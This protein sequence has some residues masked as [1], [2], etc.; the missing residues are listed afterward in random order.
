M[1]T[2]TSKLKRHYD[3]ELSRNNCPE[4]DANAKHSRRRLSISSVGEAVNEDNDITRSIQKMKENE[5]RFKGTVLQSESQDSQVQEKVVT[6]KQVQVPVS[7]E[8]AAENFRKH[9]RNRSSVAGVRASHF[10]EDFEKKCVKVTGSVDELNKNGIGYVCRKGLKPESPN[11]D[12]FIIITT[13]NLA[14]YGIF[15]G[16]GPYGHDV[17]NFVQKQLPYKIIEDKEF[18]TNPEKVFTN[19]FLEI[20]E[21]IA[22]TTQK[23]LVAVGNEPEKR[24]TNPQSRCPVASTSANE[25]GGQNQ[26]QEETDSVSDVSFTTESEDEQT[27]DDNADGND[28]TKVKKK[29]KS[30]KPYFDCTMSG[31]TATVLVHLY[32]QKKIYAAYVGDSRAVLGKRKK[33]GS[34]KLIAQDLTKDHKP[35]SPREKARIMRSGG[36][37]MKLE[38]DIPYR[39]FIKNKFYPGLAMSRAI[40]D[41]IGHQIGIVSLP[42]FVEI[43]IDE[44]EDVLVLL[45][46]DGVWEFITS[47][48][49]VNLIYEYGYNRVQDAVENLAKEAWDRWLAEEENIVDDITVQAFYLTDKDKNASS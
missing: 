18:L 20:H 1:G 27:L 37:V 26:Q 29:N 47:E 6:I 46:S 41:I 45:C 25:S 40:G 49:A 42:D 9:I 19:N 33:D 23:Y 24:R 39:V 16:H 28:S 2:C 15:D 30:S 44:D 21:T 7:S 8:E 11:Q 38:G 31:T 14:L 13:E 35:D 4:D 22:A 34:T 10:Q 32:D 3:K 36:E 5:D 43:D 48:E 17:S 12:D